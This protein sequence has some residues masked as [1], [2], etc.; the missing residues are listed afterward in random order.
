MF[1]QHLL[2]RIF[3]LENLESFKT[4]FVDQVVKEVRRQSD[5]N[6]EAREKV[7]GFC[8]ETLNSC[9]DDVPEMASVLMSIAKVD[10]PMLEVRF[11]V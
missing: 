11:R 7:I 8:F 6:K 3:H 4:K 9:K 5:W 10:I 1:A 2:Q